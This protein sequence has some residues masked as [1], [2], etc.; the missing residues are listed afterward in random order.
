MSGQ[1]ELFGASLNTL[2][3]LKASMR[4]ALR[5]CP[6]S[7][8]QIVDEMNG[9]AQ[10]EGLGGGRGAKITTANLDAWVAQTK[11]NAIP[12]TLL[13]IFCRVLGTWE[14]IRMLADPLESY[15]RDLRLLEWARIEIET[16]RMARRRK[17]LLSEIEEDMNGT[18]KSGSAH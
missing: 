4:E 7:R 13:P 11:T 1:L 12:I 2:P 18:T 6:L 15:Q 10:F 17:R 14:P 3:R 9:I 16:K 8:S 5:T